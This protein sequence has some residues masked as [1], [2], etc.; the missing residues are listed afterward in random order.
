LEFESEPTR[1]AGSVVRLAALVG[2]GAAA[3]L[4]MRGVWRRRREAVGRG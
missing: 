3:G 4:G 2:G 1:I